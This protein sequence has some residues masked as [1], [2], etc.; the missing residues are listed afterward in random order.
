MRRFG[1]EVGIREAFRCRRQV[2]VAPALAAMTVSTAAIFLAACGLGGTGSGQTP[3]TYKPAPTTTT[4]LQGSAILGTVLPGSSAQQVAAVA[5]T[6][7]N[8]VI[9]DLSAQDWGS[10]YSLLAPNLASEMSE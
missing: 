8:Q 5:N 4:T 2:R 1:G 3:V 10:L 9:A 7:A 6:V